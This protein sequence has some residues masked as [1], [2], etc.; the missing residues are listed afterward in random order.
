MTS[1]FFIVKTDFFCELSLTHDYGPAV[2]LGISD[3][4]N[5]NLA[6][7]GILFLLDF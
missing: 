2:D 4:L 3:H 7:L 6:I 1:L 5:L